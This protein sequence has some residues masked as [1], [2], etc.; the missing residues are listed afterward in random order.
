[1]ITVTMS[2]VILVYVILIRRPMEQKSAFSSLQEIQ[3]MWSFVMFM[4]CD[5]CSVLVLL[6]VKTLLVGT[7]DSRHSSPHSSQKRREKR[8]SEMKVCTQ[9]TI[10]PGIVLVPC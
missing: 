4:F 9:Y 5:L 1:M 8:E 10:L 7:F 3:K 6:A 2:N